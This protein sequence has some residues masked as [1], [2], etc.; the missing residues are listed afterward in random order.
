MRAELPDEEAPRELVA[1]APFAL[2]CVEAVF[3]IDF[4]FRVVR[5]W[6]CCLESNPCAAVPH[7]RLCL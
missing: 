7:Q 4:A 5:E 6:K 1:P 3:A 2:A